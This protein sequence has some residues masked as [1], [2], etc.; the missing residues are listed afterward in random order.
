[1]YLL[2]AD[3][4]NSLQEG[5]KFLYTRYNLPS[6]K[7]VSV[8][9]IFPGAHRISSVCGKVR[10]GHQDMVGDEDGGSGQWWDVHGWMAFLS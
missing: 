7:A 8:S 9:W 10:C 6:T 2:T 4:Q 3:N 1:M 5:H